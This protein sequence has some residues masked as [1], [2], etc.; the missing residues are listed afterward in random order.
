MSVTTALAGRPALPKTAAANGWAPLAALS[1]ALRSLLLLGALAGALLVR[2]G[3]AGT[4]GARSLPAGIAFG[5]LLT[6]FALAAGTRLTRPRVRDIGIGAAAAAFIALP[7]LR[8]HLSAAHGGALDPHQ[9]PAWAAV[10]TLVACAEEL[11]L[12]GALFSA[13]S[14]A[15]SERNAVVV[16]AV[17]FAL[18]HVPL[19][20]VR[21]LP[22]DLAVGVLLGGLRQL[23]GG[24]A[25][26]A[27]AHTL[28]DVAGWWLR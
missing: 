24:V 10:V 25:A 26:P 22:L 18:L 8:L 3:L 15:S 9:L 6:V 14:R 13:V 23:T 28:A 5:A 1:P 21:A 27:A 11:L 19:Y 4:A 7:A 17:A 2:L 16:T 20:G 12:R